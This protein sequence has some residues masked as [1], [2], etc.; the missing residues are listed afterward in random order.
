MI[1]DSARF[2]NVFRCLL[3]LVEDKISRGFSALFYFILIGAA[4]IVCQHLV[5]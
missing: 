1:F 4:V 2:F 5:A 3:T